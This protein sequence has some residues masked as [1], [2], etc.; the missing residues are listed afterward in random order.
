MYFFVFLWC[1]SSSSTIRISSRAGLRRTST[2]RCVVWLVDSPGLNSA[3]T[4]AVF[5][6]VHGAV[7]SLEDQ[8]LTVHVARSS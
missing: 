3:E 5:C 2:G 8:R 1:S 6:T 4:P 7:G